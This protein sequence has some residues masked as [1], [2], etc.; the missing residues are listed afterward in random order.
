[1]PDTVVVRGSGGGLFEVD[2]P[3]AGHA[4]ERWEEQFAK[5]DLSVVTGA[6]WVDNLDGSRS[7]TIAPPV[8]ATEPQTVTPDDDGDVSPEPVR[9][10]PGRPPKVRTEGE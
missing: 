7:L 2:V 1:M 10:G 3:T 6:R 4:R 9:R 8:A 5:G